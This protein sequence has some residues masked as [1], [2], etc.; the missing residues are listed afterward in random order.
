MGS[1]GRAPRQQP[2]PAELKDRAVRMVFDVR[3]RTGQRQG[4]WRGLLGSW[5]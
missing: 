4:R 3:E 1:R 5:G 2:Y